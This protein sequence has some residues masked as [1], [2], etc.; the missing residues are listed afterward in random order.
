MCVREAEDDVIF[1]L[2]EQ[3]CIRI[4]QEQQCVDTVQHL[5]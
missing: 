1:R 4:T 5:L 2:L 3:R